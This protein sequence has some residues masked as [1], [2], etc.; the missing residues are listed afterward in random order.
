MARVAA[1]P[2]PHFDGS[3]SQCA[4]SESWSLSSNL[5]GDGHCSSRAPGP[6]PLFAVGIEQFP[7]TVP[8]LLIRRT[9]EGLF[10]TLGRNLDD[11]EAAL[12]SREFDHRLSL[13]RFQT[14]T[15][16]ARRAFQQG[17]DG[18]CALAFAVKKGDETLQQLGQIVPRA[19][20]K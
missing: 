2:S 12:G 3:W 4:I 19:D 9:T 5:E 13:D 6:V 16:P 1:A 14:G 8:P 17:N 10:E 18:T 11:A 7:G 20:L 15:K